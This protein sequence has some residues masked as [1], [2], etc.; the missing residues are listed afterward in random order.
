VRRSQPTPARVALNFVLVIGI[1]NLFADLTYEGARSINGQFLASLGASAL[2]VGFTAGAG[3]L[4]GY[5][6][7]SITGLISDRTG[8]Y[9]LVTITG[10]LVNM[11]AVPAMALSGNWPLAGALIMAERTGRA[12][13]KPSTEA[14]L[15]HAGHQIGQG[16]V[17]GLNEALDQ[18]GATIG[19]LIMAL[20]L[21]VKGGYRQGY[22][23]LAIPAIVTIATILVARRWFPRP[24]DLEAGPPLDRKGLSR[25]YWYYL[26]AGGCLAAGFAD[27]ALIGYH[28]Q[29]VSVISPTLIPVY[30]AVAM[31]A[32]AVGALA[33]GRLHDMNQ[34]GTVLGTFLAAA[35]FAPLVFLGGPLIAL[36]GMVLWGI[37]LA[38]QESLL[39]SVVAGIVDASRRA[40]AFGLFDTGFGIAWFIGS[41]VMG[42]LYGISIAGLVIF[43][44]LLQLIGL[45]LLA[46][47]GLRTGG[48]ARTLS[49]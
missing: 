19:P 40:T 20:V 15:A 2:A 42:Y 49:A 1:A 29:K 38:A 4:L 37:G 8:R 33:L 32:G 6:L 47:A 9:W 41:V 36:G 25:R 26:V 12:I 34:A 24:S 23:L 28:F 16:W 13:R 5:G 45:P 27:F 46:F 21:F 18:A 17:F 30:Y 7:R 39:R 11:A 44:V 35:F 48:T 31:G 22:A 43:S 14:M 10:Y 3:E